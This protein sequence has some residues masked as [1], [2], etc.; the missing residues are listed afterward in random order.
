M[1]KH[2]M[3]PVDG[4]ELSLKAVNECFAFAKS[5]SASV[6]LIYVQPHYNLYVAAGF[7]SDLVKEIEKNREE[8]YEGTAQS[9]LAELE[10]RATA[11]GVQC[12]GVV[13]AGD[14]PYEA[15]IENAAKR[16]CDLIVM[17]SHGRRGLDA[18]LLGSE[19]VKVLT[20]TKI[21]VLVVR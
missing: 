3:L 10:T 16:N 5:I 13:V 7:M 14:S 2:I 4:S 11:G 20:H 17:A 9:M 1:Y 12:D 15:I 19:T 18:V 6:T 8:E 21:P